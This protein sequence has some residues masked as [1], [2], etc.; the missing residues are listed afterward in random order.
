MKTIIDYSNEGNLKVV[1]A[2]VENGVDVNYIDDKG[3]TALS[4]A[5]MKGH[6][7]LSGYINKTSANINASIIKKY[8]ESLNKKDTLKCPHCSKELS[9]DLK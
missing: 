4:Y 1:K 5:L 8:N 9:L 3:N 7:E 6:M 2:L